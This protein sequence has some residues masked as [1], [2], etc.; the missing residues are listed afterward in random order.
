MNAAPGPADDDS[1]S[2]PAESGRNA[3][4]TTA[5]QRNFNLP[6]ALTSVRIIFI[7]VFAWSVLRA[8]D[9]Y[10]GWMWAAFG[11]FA[12][13]MFTDKLDGDIARATGQVTTFGKIADPIAD[14]ALMITALVC[15]NI[16]GALPIW[17]TVLIVIRELGITL[18]RMWKLRR[19]DVVPASRGG[20]L[21]TVLQSLGVAMYLCPL[22]VWM[23]LPTLAV[24]V[25]ATAVTVVTGLQYL[26]D[27]RKLQ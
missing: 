7:P 1:G 5:F 25:L 20:K 2:R 8:D 19:G 18:W 4:G 15:L 10:V 9:E 27:A 23:D 12:A 3:E 26:W 21:K 14:K 17:I 13:L 24:M 16:T 6:N 22:P 11:I